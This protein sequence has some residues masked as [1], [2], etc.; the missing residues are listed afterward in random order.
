MF[1]EKGHWAMH[2]SNKE[3]KGGSKSGKGGVKGYKTKRFNCS[4]NHCGKQGHKKTDCWELPETVAKRP[5]SYPARNEQV[6]V[7]VECGRGGSVE[8]VVCAIDTHLVCL[9]SNY[10]EELIKGEVPK[11][12]EEAE[13]GLFN[14]LFPDRVQ[15]LEDLCIW[16]GDMV[17]ACI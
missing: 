4:C 6:N 10:P 1:K 7:H 2:C 17:V 14:L 5:V 13:L 12:A 3:A 9:Q 8:F 15:L 11:E 16:I